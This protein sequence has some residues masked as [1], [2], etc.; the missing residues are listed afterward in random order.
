MSIIHTYPAAFLAE[1]QRRKLVLILT[2]LAIAFLELDD[3]IVY[4]SLVVMVILL[5]VPPLLH[6]Y[7]LLL[8]DA[9]VCPCLC[10]QAFSRL[11]QH[12][13]VGEDRQHPPPNCCWRN[14]DR[15]LR[16]VS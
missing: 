11:Y 3:A 13:C 16:S 7:L 4:Q 15:H 9:I 10:Y 2:A 1:M 14:W 5:V 8:V 6:Y 12:H